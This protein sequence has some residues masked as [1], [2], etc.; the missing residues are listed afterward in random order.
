MMTPP[1]N[2]ILRP[3]PTEQWEEDHD[4]VPDTGSLANTS[5][6]DTSGT[7]ESSPGSS[8]T[9]ETRETT[10]MASTETSG[11]SSSDG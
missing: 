11:S 10:D 1:A 7:L 5:A 8:S 9:M 3:E 4:N 2:A 6:A